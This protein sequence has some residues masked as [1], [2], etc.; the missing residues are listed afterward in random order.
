MIQI[1]C[2]FLTKITKGL[3]KRLPYIIGF[4]HTSV[5]DIAPNNAS[6]LDRLIIPNFLEQ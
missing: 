2:N 6:K 5:R 3:K 4:K 1:E